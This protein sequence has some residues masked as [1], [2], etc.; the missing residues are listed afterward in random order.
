MTEPTPDHSPGRPLAV[1]IAVW[2]AVL[3]AVLT[4]AVVATADRPLGYLGYGAGA[5][6]VAALVLAWPVHSGRQWARLV[7]MLVA[8]VAALCTPDAANAHTSPMAFYLFLFVVAVWVAVVT[9]LL[10]VDARAYFAEL[11]VGGA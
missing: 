10:R 2:G 3:C 11:P 7:L 9:L 1:T 4:G 5:S 6:A 8:L